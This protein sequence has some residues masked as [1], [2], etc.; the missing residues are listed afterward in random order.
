MRL[1]ICIELMSGGFG[2]G[3]LWLVDVMVV[4]LVF[5]GM[6]IRKSLERSERFLETVFK[7]RGWFALFKLFKLSELKYLNS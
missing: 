2:G 4:L 3:E 7:L 1:S 6:G 5:S